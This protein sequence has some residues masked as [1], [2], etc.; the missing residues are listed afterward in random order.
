MARPD[1]SELPT[2][3]AADLPPGLAPP[4]VP[5]L[6]R[7]PLLPFPASLPV[8]PEPQ[9]REQQDLFTAGPPAAPRGPDPEAAP[10]FPGERPYVELRLPGE[11][12][13]MRI[14]HDPAVVAELV[15]L[16]YRM[17]GWPAVDELMT[18]ARRAVAK[19]AVRGRRPSGVRGSRHAEA[20]WLVEML[21]AA[22]TA[23]GPRLRRP[24]VEAELLGRT[25]VFRRLDTSVR[26]LAAHLAR[27]AP[28]GPYARYGNQ[29]ALDDLTPELLAA[30]LKDE[31]W[32]PDETCPE[33][34]QLLAV[35]ADLDKAWKWAAQV[36]AR[37]QAAVVAALA[38]QARS[39]VERQRRPG[40]DGPVLRE[41]RDFVRFVQTAADSFSGKQ[42]TTSAAPSAL[43]KT[44]TLAE[45]TE[46]RATQTVLATEAAVCAAF[47][48]ARALDL[49]ALVG[50]DAER[51][52]DAC[53]ETALE[54]VKDAATVAA[55]LGARPTSLQH[56]LDVRPDSG[57]GAE[58][59]RDCFCYPVAVYEA[60]RQAGYQPGSLAWSA[61]GEVMRA[62][63]I[64]GAYEQLWSAMDQ[65]V[66]IG[67]IA[68]KRLNLI[69]SAS[70]FALSAW[71]AYQ[72][73]RWF[74]SQS[75]AWNAV[76]DPALRLIEAEPGL[77]R[78]AAAYGMAFADLVF[79]LLDLVP[80]LAAAKVAATATALAA[81]AAAA[82][83][84]P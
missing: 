12:V 55:E 70:S 48:L 40:A 51:V 81:A 37:E 32:R 52:A 24:L 54:V 59:A 73:T 46:V 41:V 39:A 35:I 65:A 53:A 79:L 72:R 16:R 68:F 60:L 47:P 66:G 3:G 34:V 78:V 11:A 36:R 19:A 71:E 9:V 56:M 83:A 57:T 49:R 29:K 69:G 22:R 18:A 27:L 62:R 25:E 44:L 42:Q 74:S 8:V 50:A 21:R 10:D 2:V 28:K 4:G 43:L 58:S 64:P 26:G 38:A 15:E 17:G 30:R 82:E 14:R 5:P 31:P 61:A 75:T 1:E 13:P 80:Q 84:S 23:L 7:L 77:A 33:F 63:G 67:S 20:E 76:L 45:N 6:Q